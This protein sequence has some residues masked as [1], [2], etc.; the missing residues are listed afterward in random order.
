MLLTAGINPEGMIAF[1]EM[2]KKEESKTPEFLNYLSTH[3][4]TQDRIEKLKFLAN[5]SG[6]AFS[7]LYPDYEWKDVWKICKQN[8][9]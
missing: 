5:R 3:P 4:T 8:A 6:R 9:G 7:K 1:F 2:L